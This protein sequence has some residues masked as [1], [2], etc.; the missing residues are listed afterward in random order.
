MIADGVRELL[1]WG[2][3]RAQG[4]GA[5]LIEEL[6]RPGRGIVIP[7]LL[8]LFLQQVRA[9]AL[10][11]VAQQIAQPQPL[12]VGQVLGPLEQAPARLL[13]RR[14]VTLLR[15]TPRFGGAH[16]VERQVHLRPGGHPKSPSDGH[17]KIP[18]LSA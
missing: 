3:A 16:V 15:H 12:R 7:E 5:P 11:V 2:N 13:E 1:D 9:H 17:F 10:Q 4:L 14:L 6:A 18:Q 8:E